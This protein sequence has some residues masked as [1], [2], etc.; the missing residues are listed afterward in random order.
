MSGEPTTSDGDWFAQGMSDP[1][2]R[3]EDVMFGIVAAMQPGDELSFFAPPDE[4]G[5]AAECTVRRNSVGRAWVSGTS[6]ISM[7]ALDLV[8]VEEDD[9]VVPLVRE[10]EQFFCETFD[11]PTPDLLTME[12]T[13][14]IAG[15]TSGLNVPLRSAVPTGCDPA[16]TSL[17]EAVQVRDSAEIRSLFAGV[18]ETVTGEAPIVDEDGDLAFA[19][20]GA[21]VFATVRDDDPTVHLWSIVVP[22]VRSRRAAAVE[23]VLRNRDDPWTHW[24][25]RDRMVVQRTTIPAGPSVPRHM[26][27]L[28]E[29]FL[30]ALAATHSDLQMLLS[31][32]PEV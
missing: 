22:V 9:G 19:H 3:F 4:D 29:R 10:I 30:L 6:P 12:V 2:H 5:I 31:D 20:A 27:F 14:R 18:V 11:V 25:L 32:E 8:A 23:L 26:Q 7:G 24:V 1:W 16:D 17:D 13:G 15:R 21:H 28:L